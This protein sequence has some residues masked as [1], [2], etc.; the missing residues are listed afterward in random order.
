MT[1]V[2]WLITKLRGQRVGDDAYG[3]VYYRSNRTRADGARQERWVVYKG[4]AEASKVPPE[5]HSWLHHTTD[6]PITTPTKAWEKPHL[7]NLTGTDLA[8][9]PP[10]ADQKGG[11]RAPAGGDYEAWKPN[12]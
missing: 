7:P 10:G 9:M 11:H 2:T 5:W 1:L 3:N 4:D 8:Y 12:G 6:E